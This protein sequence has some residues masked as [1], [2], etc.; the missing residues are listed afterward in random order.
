MF[1]PIVPCERPHWSAPKRAPGVTT[2]AYPCISTRP[3]ACSWTPENAWH[4]PP[5]PCAAAAPSPWNGLPIR[6]G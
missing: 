1:C 4:P 5:A 3:R 6:C 2:A